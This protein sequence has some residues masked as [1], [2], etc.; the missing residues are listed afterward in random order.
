LSQQW[1]ATD[2]ALIAEERL[3]NDKTALQMV[4][5][6][7]RCATEAAD[8]L[9]TYLSRSRDD[10]S[11][12]ETFQLLSE[13]LSI[14]PE[15]AVDQSFLLRLGNVTGLPF[16]DGVAAGEPDGPSHVVEIHE[17]NLQDFRRLFQKANKLHGN[18]IPDFVTINGTAQQ[19]TTT[20]ALSH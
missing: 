14:F 4:R 15:L 5:E 13:H 11:Q 18:A 12:M 10:W 19:N 6:C 9:R 1:S 2:E 8:D 17:S 7:V 20:R 16:V 3:L